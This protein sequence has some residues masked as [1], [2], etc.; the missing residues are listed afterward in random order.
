MK[1]KGNISN[2]S[3][4]M[5]SKKKNKRCDYQE[6]SVSVVRDNLFFLILTDPSHRSRK[7]TSEARF[8]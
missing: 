7:C 3:Y 2:F 4:L 1:V 5:H 6:P 8:F